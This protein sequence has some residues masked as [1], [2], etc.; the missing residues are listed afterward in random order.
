MNKTRSKAIAKAYIKHKY[1]GAKAGLEV[2]N[3]TNKDS[4]KAMMHNALK[5]PDVKKAIQ[6]ELAEA[7]I[8]KEYLNK[9]MFTAIEKNIKEGKPSQ[10]VGAQLIIQGQKI[11][12]YLPKDSKTVLK[13]TRRVFLD[14]DYNEVKTQLEATVS[15]TQALLEDL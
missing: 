9:M 2:F 13:E 8:T 14:K 7:G 6:E 12:N 5:S 3:T 15:T 1:N 11:Y 4:A 10:A